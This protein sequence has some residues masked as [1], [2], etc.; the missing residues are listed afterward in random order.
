MVPKYIMNPTGSVDQGITTGIMKVE[1]TG[2]TAGYESTGKRPG[3]PGYGITSTGAKA[4]RGVV[5]VDPKVIPYGTYMYVPGYGYG[6]ALDTGGAIKGNKIDLFFDTVE[7]ANNWGRRWITI[8]F[9]GR[10]RD[11]NYADINLANLSGGPR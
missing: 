2:Y 9:L 1:A 6:I 5:A 7:E 3:D 10:T 11:T 8:Q 4:Q